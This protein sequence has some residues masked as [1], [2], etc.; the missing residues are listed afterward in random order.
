MDRHRGHRRDAEGEIQSN[1]AQRRPGLQRRHQEARLLRRADP[2]RLR[3]F[4]TWKS[5][6]E[7]AGMT[8]G[9][10]A[11]RRGMPILDF[12]KP[13]QDNL[14]KQGERNIYGLGIQVT[15]NGVDPIA[16][17]MRSC[18]PMA[19]R[20]SSRRRASSISTT[21]VR[22]AAVKASN[23]SLGLTATAMCRRARQLERRRRQ[24]RIPRQA[25]GDGCRRHNLDRG[26]DQGKAKRIYRRDRDRWPA[27]QQR[28]QADDCIIAMSTR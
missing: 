9:R 26:R 5:L 14:R 27:V 10:P 7:K 28:R 3:A 12:F 6:V 17:S 2:R 13:V 20:T 23:I 8:D 21:E 22:E 25:D 15:A 11:A 18:S 1:R 4:H 16:P 19:A 24:Q